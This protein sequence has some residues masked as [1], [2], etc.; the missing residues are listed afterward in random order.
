MVSRNVYGGKVDSDH[1]RKSMHGVHVPGREGANGTFFDPSKRMWMCVSRSYGGSIAFIAC[2]FT[3]DDGRDWEQ[4][5][6]R[7]TL[8]PSWMV[9]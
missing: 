1:V 5:E 6:S 3:E 7:C 8:R 4:R 2:L 9:A